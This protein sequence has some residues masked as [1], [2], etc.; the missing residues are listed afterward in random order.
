MA[1]QFTEVT[2][3]DM[4]RFLKR[5]YRALRP[6]QGESRG[7]VYY[8][9]NLS[10]NKIFIRVW[11]SIRPRSGTG[12][13]V[14][15]D[16]IRVTMITRA[17]K[18]LMPKGKIV[19]RTQ[20]W[21]NSL[22]GRIEELL[23]TYEAKTG[24]WKER[25]TNRDEGTT[26]NQPKEESKQP[27]PEPETKQGE[28]HEGQFTKLSGGDWGAKIFGEGHEGD[29]AFLTSKGGRRVKAV[30]VRRVWKGADRFSG[31]YTEIWTAD[32]GSGGGGGR[33]YSSE[34]ASDGM[35][36]RAILVAERYLDRGQAPDYLEEDGNYGVN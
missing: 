19:K 26:E 22:Q 3:E 8:D 32:I 4:E 24:Y 28:T 23:E 12:A 30:L 7:E 9:L 10:D 20:N 27:L 35:D 5:A 1:A 31:K 6:K 34:E 29:H 17:G 14:G 15:Q 13:G 25:Q 2:L 11:T 18:P 16:A 21:R 36:V 33:K